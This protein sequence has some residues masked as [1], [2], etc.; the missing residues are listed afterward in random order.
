MIRSLD[1]SV[2][3]V[4]NTHYHNETHVHVEVNRRLW[5]AEDDEVALNTVWGVLV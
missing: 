3:V 2:T 4:V 1:T 5:V